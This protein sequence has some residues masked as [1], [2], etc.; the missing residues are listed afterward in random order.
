MSG[1]V[2]WELIL[3]CILTIQACLV[4]LMGR[5]ILDKGKVDL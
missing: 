2:R 3:A 1:M 4:C 5:A